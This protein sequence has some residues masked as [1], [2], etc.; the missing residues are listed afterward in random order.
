MLLL[1]IPR[2]NVRA[3][4]FRTLLGVAGHGDTITAVGFSSDGTYVSTASLDGA[5]KYVHDGW[6][7]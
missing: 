1:R 4:V 2:F 6:V 3:D 5:V 7:E